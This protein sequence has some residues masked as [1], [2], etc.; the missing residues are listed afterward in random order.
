MVWDRGTYAVEG[1]DDV[2]TAL[3]KGDLKFTL[4][5]TKLKGSWVLVRTRNRQWLLIKHR[6]RYASSND[7][8]TATAPTSVIT[9]RKLADIAADEGGDVE[10]AASGDQPPPA[11]PPGKRSAPSATRAARSSRT[12]KP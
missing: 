10:K 1:P 11:P 12:K 2:A 5:G 4:H 8:I 7:D 9:G 6:D 3:D